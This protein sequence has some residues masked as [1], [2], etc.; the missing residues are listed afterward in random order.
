[1]FKYILILFSSVALSLVATPVVRRIAIG[2]GAI[3][4]PGGRRTHSVPTPRFGGLAVLLAII[5]GLAVAGLADSF[6]AAT[7]LA[8]SA[9][10]A[11]LF[12]ATTVLT[13]VGLV[14]DRRS[15]GPTLKLAVEILAGI[16]AVAAGC[17]IDMV[18]RIDLGWF[19]PTATVFW[20]VAIINAVNMI[21][22][23]DGLAAGAGLIISATLF[24]ISLYLGN[25][26]SSFILAALSGALLGF[27]C[28]NFHPARIFLGDSGS[29]FIGF[30]LAVSAIQSSSKAATVTAIMWPLLALGLPVAELVLTTPRR[31]LRVVRVVRLDTRAQRYEF[32]FFGSATLFTADRDHIHHRLLATGLTHSRVVAI[33]YGVCALFGVGSFLLVINYRDANV[34]LLILGFG[35]AAIAVKQL[36]YRELQPFRSGLLLPLFDL[37][38][39]NR[40][41][42]CVLFDLAF[43]SLS[44]L[45]ASAILLNTFSHASLAP[46]ITTIPLLAAVKIGCFMLA[47]L[48]RRSYRYAGIPDLFALGKA[49]AL[50]TTGAWIVLFAAG[51]GRCPALSIVVLDAY[52]LAT[53]L[54]GSR[55]S[56]RL[57]DYLFNLNRPGMRRALIY[58]AGRGGVAAL[59]EIRSNP[60][61]SLRPVGFIDDDPRK[62]GR[63]LQGVPVYQ[64]GE[65]AA[66]IEQGKT[67]AVVI[68][69]RK[70]P[71]EELVKVARLCADAGIMLRCFQITLD[72]L[73]RFPQI[74][75]NDNAVTECRADGAANQLSEGAGNSAA[76]W[77]SHMRIGGVGPGSENL[78]QRLRSG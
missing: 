32:S 37:P 20:I 36:D 63:M 57:L 8:H 28:Y 53:L 75:R 68:A 50:S 19:G 39:S 2:C 76:D 51:Y 44:Y 72:E 54:L 52:L 23:L 55:V 64:S 33:L 62:R 31:T 40:R 29:L 5:F 70:L 3:D 67:D 25:I 10:V 41:L 1:V 9:E 56:F 30:L 38:A 11:G 65:L 61:T 48:Y 17:R 22:G 42:V 73:E 78:R 71:R 14:D 58:G 27:L 60:A 49:I 59:H 66:L 7:L 12:A 24:S 46:I 16:I 77:P 26:E 35:L 47:G 45:A 21:D 6:V 4:V 18:V 13:V 74:S 34:L 15:L 43:I 69:T